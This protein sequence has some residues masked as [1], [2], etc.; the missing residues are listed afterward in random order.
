M[1]DSV[2]RALI[3]QSPDAVILA[4]RAGLITHWNMAA[5]V[6]FGF[7][8]E[9]ALGESLDIIVPI[10]L[11]EAHW[12]GFKR[13]IKT[14]ETRLGGRS[15][16]TKAMRKDGVAVY[17]DMSFALIHSEDG[18]LIGAAAYCRDIDARFKQEKERR[19]RLKELEQHLS[20]IT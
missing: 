15:L 18:E 3:E 19:R 4:D 5:E 16:P 12:K 14:E 2:Y 7:T 11:R 20:R 6:L 1:E 10:N 9:E 8:P 13:S 17:V